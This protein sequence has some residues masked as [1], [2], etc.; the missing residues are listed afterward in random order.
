MP[1]FT[2]IGIQRWKK[3]F[4]GGAPLNWQ[5]ETQKLPEDKIK[6]AEFN[7]N[8]PGYAKELELVETHKQ[9][10]LEITPMTRALIVDII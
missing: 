1:I 5:S 8:Y 4:E 2:I 3:T 10:Q 7:K 9:K 6:L